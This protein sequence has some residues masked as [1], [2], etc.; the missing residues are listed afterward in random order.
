[1]QIQTPIV[2]INRSDC[3]DLII[4]DYR[5][6][7]NKARRILIDLHARFN[8]L[9]IIRLRHQIHKFLI[10]DSRCDN[11]HIDPA[12][13]RKCQRGYHLIVDNQIRR[14][15]IHIMLCLVD[16]VQV[17]IL[18]DDFIVHRRIS[19][20]LYVAIREKCNLLMFLRRIRR[21]IILL[22]G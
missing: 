14:C 19:I 16:H 10:R 21:I 7:M 5:L 8:Q 18:T 12:F 2:K 1:M 15:N 9:I 20:W 3:R 11:P 22:S 17:D 6:R 4:H 13:C